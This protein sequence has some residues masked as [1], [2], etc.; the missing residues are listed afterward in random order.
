VTTCH[1]RLETA[2]RLLCSVHPLWSFALIAAPIVNLGGLFMLLLTEAIPLRIR[3]PVSCDGARAR[4]HARTHALPIS[5]L[6][7]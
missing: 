7:T 2:Q 4:A 1:A 6:R 5:P 3:P